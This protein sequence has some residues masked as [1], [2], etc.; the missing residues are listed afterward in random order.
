MKKIAIGLIIFQHLILHS[1]DI[2]FKASAPSTVSNGSQ[3]KVVYSVNAKPSSFKNP[4]FE[5]FQVIMG[6]STSQST[7][8]SFINGQMSQEIS[9][10]YTYYLLATK[11]GKYTIQPA[12]IIVNGKT[13][14]SNPLTIEV[15][16]GTTPPPTA[17]Q[18]EH[19]DQPQPTQVSNEDVFIRV[20]TNKQ[21]VYVGE[22]L[23]ASIYIYTRLNIVGFEDLKF[24]TMTG[25]WSEDLE[26]PNQIQLKQEYI[27]GQLYSVGL[28]KRV[29]LSPNKAGKLTIEPIQASVVVQQKVK[30]QRRSFWDDFFATYQNVSKKLVS[31]PV[32][33]DV[34]P[35]PENKPSS[36]SGG[37]GSFNFEVKVDN[38]NV[39]MNEALNYTIRL[40]GWGNIK[41]VDIPKPNFPT[42]FEV[43]DPKITEN[44]NVKEGYTQGTRTLSYIVIPRHYG[45]YTIPG[46][47]FSYFDLKTKSYKTIK[48][49]DITI[50]VA[51]DSLQAPSA[52]I[53]ELTKKDISVIG[54]DIRY[55]KTNVE[56]L[57]KINNFYFG[58]FVYK[59]SYPA[60]LLSLVF[61]LFLRKEQIKKRSNLMALRN[62]KA[63]KIAS[64]RFKLAR[65]Y[66]IQQ[67]TNKF[68]EEITKAL[69]GYLADKLMIPTAELNKEKVF[70]V[71]KNKNLDEEI[72]NQLFETIETCEVARYAPSAIHS[73]LDEIYN[74][75]VKQIEII[76]NKI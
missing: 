47:T 31:P 15:V 44:I 32:I 74:K 73:S 63:N 43:Y 50:D 76:E 54:S 53:S 30:S 9:F 60:I 68:Y 52:I 28:L 58:K 75:A 5:P 1:Q 69:W 57:E 46:L 3:F 13:Y 33:I 51:K 64:K 29:I 24:P 21:S 40:S 42:D 26:N 20:Q 17:S 71:L 6:P 70:E 41:L 48:T 10:S 65:K 23:I 27:N 7:N 25:F 19:W 34:K 55:A 39:K 14:K 4:S 38:K 45:Q 56:P 62:K 35:L 36:F 18:Y 49:D 12:E 61:L 8:I 72:I 16:K 59:L 66:L 67:D 2:Q 11:E 22:Q 37:V